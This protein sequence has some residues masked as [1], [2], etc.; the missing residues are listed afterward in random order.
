MKRFTALLTAS[1]M[2]LATVSFAGTKIS[3][4]PSASSV[5]AGDLVPIVQS[6]VNKNA[7]ASLITNALSASDLLTKIKTVD[8]V[9]SG[10]DANLLDGNPSS[11]YVT[12]AALPG[13]IP[14]TGSVVAYV[15]ATAPTGWLLCNGQSVLSSSYPNL[16][17]VIYVGD[18]YNSNTSILYGYKSTDSGG[19]TRSTAGTYIKVPDLR[20]EFIRGFDSSRG[21]DSGRAW[22]TAQADA[23]KSHN[24]GIDY[25]TTTGGAGFL[26]V[27]GYIDNAGTNNTVINSAGGD[28]TRPRNITMNYIIKY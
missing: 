5:S 27:A 2:L 20:G 23:F 19:V 28:E 6:G 9:G 17:A 18:A 3:A 10:L 16:S 21:V 25:G 15:G 24:H 22:A 1:L 7:A 8:G 13:Y 11:Y 14:P 26:G 12:M 4:M